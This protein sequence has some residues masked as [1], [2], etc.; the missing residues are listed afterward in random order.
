MSRLRLEGQRL[1]L[2]PAGCGAEK[3]ISSLKPEPPDYLAASDGD[4]TYYV[5]DTGDLEG[6]FAPIGEVSEFTYERVW[7]RPVALSSIERDDR[8]EG[9]WD[10]PAGTRTADGK[11]APVW[12]WEECPEQPGAIAYYGA[13]Y[14]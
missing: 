4:W 9:W 7:L 11:F 12:V 13:R 8:P 5:L 14:A 2:H 3:V 10:E 1:Q 6:S